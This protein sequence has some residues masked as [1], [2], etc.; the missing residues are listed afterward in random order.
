MTAART[1]L[2]A[3]VLAGAGCSTV[4]G[5]DADRYVGPAADAAGYGG[6]DASAAS[7]RDGG[8]ASLPASWGCLNGPH[9]E[10]EPT[11]HVDV[12]VVVMDAV[13][14]STSAGAVDGGSDLDTLSAGWLSGV[15]VRPCDLLD[16]ACA[17]AAQAVLTNDAGAAEFALTGDFAG[18]FDLRRP[19]LVPA[20]L[21]PG[22]LL[23]GQT[24]A[25]FPAY[26]IH[27]KDL[28]SLAGSAAT[29]VDLDPDSGVGQAIVTIYDCQ[30]HQASG[31]S[32]AY[33]GLDA[34]AAVPFYFSGGLPNTRATQTDSYG[35]A[36]AINVPV[37]TLMAT[38]TLA[39]T[40][41][42]VG[43]IAF[44]IRAGAV[45]FAWIRVRSH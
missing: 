34:Q 1:L 24:T 41:T 45:S 38:A 42:M 4:M 15:A 16:P 20:T 23:A 2:G 35:I 13:Q 43:S 40:A 6:Q 9:E 31:I 27:P 25:S 12:T 17:H 5:I 37:G 3:G 7:P 33:E 21:Y 18:F 36:G 19:D 14:P 28:R 29:T 22:H 11:L 26:T 44:D 30:D 10:L 39:S 32:V 8:G